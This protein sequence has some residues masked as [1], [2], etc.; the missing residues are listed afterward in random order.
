MDQVSSIYNPG[1]DFFGREEGPRA[2]PGRAAVKNRALVDEK[3]RPYLSNEAIGI[4]IQTQDSI[5]EDLGLYIIR[6]K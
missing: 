4:S 2:G 1:N 6:T 5:C 3:S